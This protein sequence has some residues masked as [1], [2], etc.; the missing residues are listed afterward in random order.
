MRAIKWS[1]VLLM[2]YLTAMSCSL[3]HKDWKQGSIVKEGKYQSADLEITVQ[4]ENDLV[5]F[6]VLNHAGNILFKNPHSFSALH[7]WAL[8]LD[9]EESLWVLSGDIGD[10][11]F[12][13]DSTGIYNYSQ[14]SHYL[15]RKDVPD[16]MYDDL[17]DFVS[18][19]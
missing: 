2:I 7:K 3:N 17:K 6:T 19:R 18:L 11:I 16:Y 4:V 9:K 14:F 8:Y 1:L 13:K 15:R 12:K 10:S 5:S